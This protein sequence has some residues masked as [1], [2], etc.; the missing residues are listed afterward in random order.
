MKKFRIYFIALSIF[1]LLLLSMP[2][3]SSKNIISST[4]LSPAAQMPRKPKAKF[5]KVENA[6]SNRYIVVLND[7]VSP[8]A[9]LNVR[10]AQVRAVA[11]NLAQV[12]GGRLGFIYDT[13]LKGFSIELPGEA[14]AIALSQ[15]PRVDWVEEEGRLYPTTVQSNP[16][17]GLDRIDQT[18]LP[19]N[20]EYVFNATG[21]GV[22]AYV[23]DSGIRATHVEFQGRAS[24][25]ADF[26]AQGFFFDDCTP[27]STYN[28]CV[29]HGTHVAGT[30]GGATYGVAKSV[31]IRSVKVCSDL[32]YVGCPVSAVIA[33][34]D[35]TT[36]DHA[37]EPSIPVVA[38]MSLGGASN[39]SLDTAVQNSINS[40][41]TYVIAAGNGDGTGNGIDA[42]SVSPAH[43]ADAL[44]VGASDINDARTNFSNFGK[45]VDLYAP[46]AGVLS[47]WKDSDTQ[48]LTISGTSMATP[49][50]TGSVALYLQ[51]RTAMTNCAANPKQGPRTTSGSTIATCPDRVSQFIASNASL[52]KLTGLNS[53]TANRLLFTASLPATTNPID[54]SRF[55]FW[56]Q[57]VDFLNRDPDN[58]GLSF[59][60][61][62][63]TGCGSDAECIKATRAALSANFFR[64]PE[65]GQRG[66]FVANLFNIVFGQRPKTVAELSDPAKVERPHYAEFI[67]DFV[68]LTGTDAEVSVKKDQLADTWMGRPEV[69]AILPSSLSNQQFVQKLES[70]AGG[71]TLANESTLI[72]NLNN[73]T[74]SRAQVLRAVAESNEVTTKFALQNFVTMQYI[75]HLRREPEDCHGSPDPANCGYIFHYNRFPSSGDPAPTENLITRGFIE[76]TEYRQRFGP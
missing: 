61:N 50:T 13:A 43:V 68:P 53:D 1:V 37:A 72:A 48:T 17:W 7:V 34:V 46:G 51:T 27:T 76:S 32:F 59:Y 49:H 54:N 69:Q 14:A 40:G 56:Q 12:H 65:F 66:G 55:F 4:I 22:R 30:I 8:G 24:I 57:Y 36:S 5:N 45:V 67:A 3:T 62:I 71:V 42:V 38:N 75:G 47:A 60:V 41:V 6:F 20:T 21:E 23:I 9:S 11:E 18:S 19:L 29:G 73:N 58:G 52:D 2:T 33:G 25:R 31:T 15:N 70:I 10:R 63:L 26:I 74:Q 39:S 35:F 44:T 28:D 64:S 16:P